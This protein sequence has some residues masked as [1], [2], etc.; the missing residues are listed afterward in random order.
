MAPE[1]TAPLQ[2][3]KQHGSVLFP[4]NIY[5]CTIPL[6]FP[7]VSLHWHKSMELIYVKKGRGEVQVGTQLFTAEAGDI[8]ILPPSTLHALR[9]LP[10]SVMEYENLIFD[11]VFLGSGTADICAQQYLIPLAAGRLPL[12]RHLREGQPG[13][14]GA[15]ACLTEA[16]ALCRERMTGYELEVRAVMLRF[17]FLLMQVRMPPVPP[18]HPDTQ[19][20]K[21]VLRRVETDYAQ[22]LSVA[23]IARYCGCSSSHFMRWFKQMT[24][25]SFIS[26][27]NERRLAA[28]AE[29]L[30]HGSDT[31]LAVSQA[32]GFETLSN[33]NRQF[34]ARYGVT[35]RE[36][37]RHETPCPP[38]G[39]SD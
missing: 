31:V 16:E 23:D 30:R 7:S 32:A 34:K 24:G 39:P 26:Y 37:R 18:E 3:T 33:F 20:L 19:R 13:Y 10:G 15:A 38:H 11:P 21:D 29:L 27:L 36:Y 5:P 28:A 12:P 6:D 17:L 1:H 14:A 22:P 25:T 35:P 9:E 4:F 2:E 8:F